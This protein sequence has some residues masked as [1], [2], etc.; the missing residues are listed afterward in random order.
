MR[1]LLMPIAERSS[2]SID[3]FKSI[4]GLTDVAQR[5]ISSSLEHA[6]ACNILLHGSPGTGK[7]ECAKLLA[8]M[9]NA[10]PVFVGVED[11]DGGEPTSNERINH[12]RLLR[13]LN[14]AT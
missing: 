2:L 13:H 14:I 4:T 3:D 10:N 1:K 7:T 12:L 8:S 9:A 11:E 5:L 6:G